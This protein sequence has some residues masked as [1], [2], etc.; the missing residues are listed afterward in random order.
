MAGLVPK[1]PTNPQTRG[2]E[3]SKS[4]GESKFLPDQ[5][6]MWTKVL[7]SIALVVENRP[8]LVERSHSRV[9]SDA[10]FDRER[11]TTTRG[12][13]RYL[14]PFLDSEHSLFRDAA[15]FCI[16]SFPAAG[17]PQLLEDLGLLLHRQLFDDPR[18]GDPRQ[19]AV[20]TFPL[21]RGRRQERLFTAVARIYFLTAHYLQDQRSS[22]RQAVLSLVLRFVRNTQTLLTSPESRDNFK[23]QRLR[24]YFC[25]TVERLFDGL[26][27]LSDADRFIPAKAHLS[28]YRLCE[29]W[30]QLGHQ[31]EIVKQRL[32]YMQRSAT[33]AVSSPSERGEAVVLFQK[34]TKVLSKA[35]IAAM[36]SL[37]VSYLIGDGNF[38][39]NIL[40]GKSVLSARLVFG[41]SYGWT[42][43]IYEGSGSKGNAGSHTRRASFHG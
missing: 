32:I 4:F 37:C 39:L 20:L 34:E 2:S 41:I 31:S 19:K 29:E 1:M 5:W 13:I 36:A 7:S 17:Y 8:T 38:F 18:I 3:G 11:L 26:N 27:S 40:L 25:G 9:P 43:G 42:T 12:L 30:C 14:T 16:S 33:E 15:V 10:S 24:R 28:L 22:A 23:F 6:Y 35:A 21:E